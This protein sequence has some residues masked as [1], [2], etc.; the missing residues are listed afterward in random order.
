MEVIDASKVILIANSFVSY[1]P[2]NP[3]L[4]EDAQ[5]PTVALANGYVW[6]LSD[7]SYSMNDGFVASN[8]SGANTTG[9]FILNSAGGAGDGEYND[10]YFMFEDMFGNTTDAGTV[11]VQLHRTAP[12]ALSVTMSG[13]SGE[14]YYTGYYRKHGR[15][16]PSEYVSLAF[17]ASSS[18]GMSYSITGDVKSPI[19]GDSL[20]SGVT[21]RHLA[22]VRNSSTP[23][24]STERHYSNTRLTVTLA[25]TD[26]AGNRSTATASIA[27]IPQLNRAQHLNLREQGSSYSH[28]VYSFSNDT[29]SEIQAKR[30]SSSEYTRSWNE[31]WYPSTHG[32]P[33]SADGSIDY[34]EAYRI[35]TSPTASDLIKYDRLALDS[36]G[37]RLAVDDD[38]R[39]MQN[40][41]A[42]GM[43]KK[44]PA[45]E[46]SRL[47]DDKYQTYWI[48]DNSGNPDFQLEFEIF[49]FSSNVT[50]YPE[51]LCARYS[52]DSLSVFDASDAGC[53][54]DNPT[55]DENGNRMWRLKDSTKLS[56][57]FTIKGSG[58]D[59]THPPTLMDSEV[60]GDIV[61]TGNGFTCPSI[62]QCSR[63]CI[64]PFTDYGTGDD[65]RGSGFKL[66]AGPKHYE[67][68][69]NYESIDST[70]EFWVHVS[71][72]TAGG[73]WS[74]PS[75]VTLAYDYYDS[76]ASFDY[77]NGTVSL[78]GRPAYPLMA[79]FSH[80]LALYKP[81]HSP[82]AGYPHKYF[83][84]VPS[85]SSTDAIR[86]FAASQDDFVDYANKA[87]YV[88]YSGSEPVKTG[89]YDATATN[90]DSSGKLTSYSLDGD[91]GILSFTTPPF[92]RIFATYYYHTY[93]RL[94]SDGYGDLYFYGGGVL[95]PASSTDSYKDWTYVD[96]KIVNEGSNTL[97][98]GFLT[99]LARGYIT[100]GSVVDT[101][102]DLNRPW[103]VQEG[104]T[105]E[106]VNRT[107]AV[108][109]TSFSALNT[110]SAYVPSRENAFNARKTQTCSIGTIAPKETV[111]VRVFWTI[112][113]N[114]QGTA[115]VDCTK[116]SKT[117]SCEMSGAYFIFTS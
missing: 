40:V 29:H 75:S 74:C 102:L 82:M 33:L 26:E 21:Y 50:A 100:K 76:T 84:T 114:A 69:D 108:C 92:G 31:I 3:S 34:A 37:T 99:F 110:N 8:V 5:N 65:Q 16:F 22:K 63:I 19:H 4:S 59:S 87:F 53:V 104:T 18:I 112:A 113:N 30:T 89:L 103:D 12:S 107:G 68:F 96:V 97:Q 23:L 64:V 91:M 81:S 17:T 24:L 47:V 101:V 77:E 83:S 25:V 61:I 66:K 43:S 6:S 11:R 109:A 90:Y 106:T 72:E 42:W 45:K 116:G 35:A 111:Y 10:L 28:R 46:N 36:T 9:L 54:Y 7:I 1:S 49:D 32:S 51:N 67:E 88:S 93:Y 105:A 52:G 85:A 80:Y 56:H 60:D 98:E 14:P 41:N 79:T 70:G 39:Y 2:Q 15:F 20:A 73:D 27:Y 57:L 86:T 94:T 44:Y 78:S 38:G 95:V 62:S 71:P 115:W 13:S 48:I 55:I 117:F 58:F